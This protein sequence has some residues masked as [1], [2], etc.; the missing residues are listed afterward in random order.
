MNLYLLGFMGTGKTSIGDLL[1]R[2]TKKYFVDMDILIE[3]QQ[4]K[5]IS[6]IFEQNGEGAFRE[7]EKKLLNKLSK[8]K[9]LIVGTGGGIIIDQDNVD[10]MKS[11]GTRILLT[12][13]PQTIFKRLES[14]TTRP[15]LKK[16]NKLEN[17]EKILSD[18][19]SK[20][21]QAADIV[22]DTDSKSVQEIV[23]GIAKVL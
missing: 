18:R 13:S 23:E 20:Y 5:T 16:G 21:E 4:K 8:E 22:V 9:D 19:A 7:I 17:I 14:D 15:L 3:D 2:K 11:T 6:K 10:I 12:A 1:A